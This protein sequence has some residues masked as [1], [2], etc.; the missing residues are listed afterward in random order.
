MGALASEMIRLHGEVIGVMPRALVDRELAND[1]I[2]DLRI[3]GS[4]HERK[5]LMVELADGFLALPGGYGTLD[6]FCEVLTWAQLG[7]HQKPCGVL[8]VDGY[9]DPLLALFDR[10]VAFA[11]LQP[12]NRGLVLQADQP[13]RLLEM[14]EAFTPIPL[15]KWITAGET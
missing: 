10:A 8:N 13:E 11:F 3:V 6:E 12:E 15:P 4:M 7:L 14:M 5:A 2:D 1:A 9:F